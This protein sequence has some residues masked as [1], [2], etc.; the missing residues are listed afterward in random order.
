MK[1]Q[2]YYLDVPAQRGNTLN[3]EREFLVIVQYHGI[4][5][6]VLKTQFYVQLNNRI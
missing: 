3:W 2:F 4:D 5:S 6:L 1:L